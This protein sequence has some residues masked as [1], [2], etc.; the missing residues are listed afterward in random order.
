MTPFEWVFYIDILESYSYTSIMA[1]DI[2]HDAVK[3]ALIKDGWRITHDPYNIRYLTV[4]LAADLGAERPVAA[5]RAGQKIVVEIKSFAGLSPIQD[6]KLALGQYVLYLGYLEVTEPDR[7]LYLAVDHLI[8][9]E[10]LE[11][12]A[13][14]FIRRRYQIAMLVV[15]IDAEEVVKWI[16]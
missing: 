7:K 15:N 6:L 4:K 8:Y 3:N 12:E 9:H 10:F 13:I 2:I 16:D 1:K 14:E 11:Q 5:E